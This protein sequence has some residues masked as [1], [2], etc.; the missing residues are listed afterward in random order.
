MANTTRTF[1]TSIDLPE[2]TR[3]AVNTMLNQTLADSLDLYS[4]LKQAHWN[5]KGANFYQ[6]HLLFDTFAG[7]AEEWIDMV[8]ERVT[9]LGGYAT[10]TARMAAANSQLP[11]YP[12]DAVD[13]ADHL[14]AVV[15]RLAQYAAAVRKGIA[16]S[17]EL[18]DIATSDLYTEIS[19]AV[20]KQLWFA[21][22][23]LQG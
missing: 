11:E 1:R 6:L 21:E 9:A 4:Q 10:G 16:D 22:A 2:T 20:D 7:E 3:V 17:D 14:R 18:G 19:R 13:G 23:H 12:V 15:D 8:A 5:I